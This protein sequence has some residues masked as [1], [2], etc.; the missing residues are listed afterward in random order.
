[1]LYSNIPPTSSRRFEGKHFELGTQSSI[2]S[3]RERFGE[4]ISQLITGRNM[5]NIELLGQYLL[6]DKMNV[7]LQMLRFR[8]QDRVVR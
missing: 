3:R 6:S 4:R 1:L 5:K 7:K 8:M 2:V